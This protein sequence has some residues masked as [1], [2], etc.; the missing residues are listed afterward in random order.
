M[1]ILFDHQTF[2]DQHA[3]G[4][5]RYFSSLFDELAKD[6]CAEFRVASGLTTNRYLHD[7]PDYARAHV[8]GVFVPSWF[9]G[10]GVPALNRL[11]FATVV[12]RYKP[13]IYHP[14][15]Y[16]SLASTYKGPVVVTVYDMIHET[17]PKYALPRDPTSQRKR[18]LLER[19]A[20]IICLSQQTADDLAAALPHL[21]AMTRVVHLAPPKWERIRRSPPVAT[22]YFLYVG[23]RG[24]YK[25][26]KLLFEAFAQSCQLRERASIICFGGGPPTDNEREQL[27]KLGLSDRVSFLSGDDSLLAS[28]Y[29]YAIAYVQTSKAEGFGLPLLEAM[30][31]HCPVLASRL[32]V[33]LEVAADAAIFF[34][35]GDVGQL[36]GHMEAIYS[37]QQSRDSHIQA[38]LLRAREFSWRRNAQETLQFY[39]DVLESWRG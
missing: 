5:S 21:Q 31:M 38:G 19:A 16:R 3:G 25:D 6:T 7:L 35:P 36:T 28:L 20:G 4:I 27:E 2:T 32:P 24:L 11:W 23:K 15:Y 13:D 14:T 1:R 18:K 8:S 26:A 22:P 39:S 34:A 10:R 9:G 37:D 30:T 33:T 17:L 29:E 12:A